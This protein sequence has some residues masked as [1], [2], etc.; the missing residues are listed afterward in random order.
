[1]ARISAALRSLSLPDNTTVATVDSVSAT[2]STGSAT[3]TVTG[4]ASGAAQITASA[5]NGSTTVT[6]S[7]A[8]LTVEPG[9]GQLLISEFRTRG[10]AGAAD[11]FV[12]IYNPT[13]TTQ[14]IGGLKIRASNSA[15]T[16]SD[17]VTITAGT[18][19]GSGCHYLIA[20]SSSGGYSGSVPANQTYGTGI[21][22][23]GGIAITRVEWHDNH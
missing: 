22:D 7:P 23:D 12:E 15:G 21:A 5:N 2:S 18:T 8:T 10:P 13:T 14:V 17:R 6:S 16:I 19:L 3:A 9:A 4:R 20:N 1:M 11:E